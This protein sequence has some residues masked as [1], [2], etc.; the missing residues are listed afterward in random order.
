MPSKS[1]LAIQWPVFRP[2]NWGQ[3]AR[4]LPLPQPWFGLDTERD[5]LLGDFVCG[6]AV[7]ESTHAFRRMDDLISGTYWVWNL[8]YDIEGMLRD[9]NVPEA[10][11]AREDG[12]EFPLLGGKARYFHGKR[13][14]L[15]LPGKKISFIEA[16]SF[17]NRCALKNIGQKVGIDGKTMSLDRYQNDNEPFLCRLSDKKE[18][19]Y[20]EAVNWYCQN[21]ALLVFNAIR[22]LEKGIKALGVELG[23]TPGATARGFLN[24]LG[25]FADVLWRTHHHFLKSYCGGRFEI[26]KRGVFDE[27]I[28][29]YDIVSAYPWALSQCPWLSEASYHRWTNRYSDNAL[30]G[31]Y[32]VDFDYDNYLGLA[33]TW[34]Q[35]IRVYSKAEKEVWLTRPELDWLMKKGAKIRIIKAI[36]IFDDNASDLWRQII[37]ELFAMKR[38]APDEATKRGAKVVLNSQYGVLIQLIRL[39]GIWVPMNKAKNPVDFVGTLALE[40]PPKEFEGGKY[41]APAFAG[42][43]TGLVRVKLLDAAMAVGDAAYIGGH[44]DSVITRK[45]LPDSFISTELGGW[46]LEETALSANI[47]K[48]GFYSIGNKIKMRGI[49]KAGNP[50]MLWHTEL[51]RNTR[52]G[53]KSAKHWDEVSLIK[54][55]VVVN[56]FVVEK[57]RKWA[58]DLSDALIQRKEWVDSEAYAYVKTK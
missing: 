37:A 7:G 42:N 57:K 48:T 26:V 30:Y 52:Q 8:A 58:Q 21:D 1:E 47:C 31:S 17:Y 12:S 46:G 23:G 25:P 35:G 20:R 14:N 15:K 4:Q 10:W 13:F 27:L 38:D 9:L 36:E 5:A 3:P 40:E 32:C 28:Y 45:K 29:Q 49:T 39:C 43:L 51:Q 16:S 18:M 54:Q 2:R 41:Y 24:R 11:A 6:Y 34:K 19:T 33:P 44:T 50:Q 55:K 22:D 56:N 53:I